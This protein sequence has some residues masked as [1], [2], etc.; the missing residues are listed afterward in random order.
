VS[1]H[2]LVIGGQRCGTTYLHTLLEGHPD[3]AMARP[4]RPEPKVFLD[5]ETSSRGLEWYHR[6]F[7]GHATTESR[8]GEKSTSYI[9]SGEA[10]TRA[11]AVL[12]DA[13]VLV[14]L[15][16]P[17]QRAVSNWR[18]STDN[19]H[20]SRP[21][22]DAL[23][24][25]LERSRAWKAEETSVS[26]FAY[27]ERGRFADYLPPW[28]RAFPGRV[29]VHLLDDLVSD[30]AALAGLYSGLG[31]EPSFRPDAFGEAVNRSSQPAPD[32]P[33]DLAHRVRAY[34]AGSDAA[35]ADRLG[36]RLPWPT[37]TG[38]PR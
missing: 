24:E 35:L 37:T 14:L 10:A 31:V 4:A 3:I 9:E 33:E 15:R 12:G 21:L 13:D 17:L 18:F 1:R 26:P 23:E 29:Q 38:E 30:V 34:F 22:V 20:E 16:D 36:R 25:N 6:T 28:D 2:F 5:G 19:G 7:F 8:W 32:L 11:A 27:L